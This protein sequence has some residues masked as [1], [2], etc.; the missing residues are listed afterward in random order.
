MLQL[1]QRPAVVVARADGSSDALVRDGELSDGLPVGM[2]PHRQYPR[3]RSANMSARARKEQDGVGV[4]VLPGQE[5]S[6]VGAD[7][8]CYRGQVVAHSAVA[9]SRRNRPSVL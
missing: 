3:P 1:A 2:P 8:V 6:M 9:L 4:R 7:G 5:F